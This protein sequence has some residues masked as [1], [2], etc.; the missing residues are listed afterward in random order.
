MMPIYNDRF[1]YRAWRREDGLVVRCICERFNE[2]L[3][4]Y[5]EIYYKYDPDKKAFEDPCSREDARYYLKTP[6]FKCDFNG[7]IEED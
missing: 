3:H 7:E 1:Q 2:L 4:I 6:H 5:W